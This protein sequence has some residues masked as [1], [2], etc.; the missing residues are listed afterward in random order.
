MSESPSTDLAADIT[1]ELRAEQPADQ[2]G[3]ADSILPP[4]FRHKRS[5]P[6]QSRIEEASVPAGDGAGALAAD[7]SSS[8]A[9][10]ANTLPQPFRGAQKHA[11]DS[12]GTAD[13][14]AT[15]GD[16]PARTSPVL[17]RGPYGGA[18]QGDE[19]GEEDGEEDEDEDGLGVLRRGQ[20]ATRLSTSKIQGRAEPRKPRIGPQYQAVVP[21]WLG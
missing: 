15:S 21:P 18:D 11:R 10:L 3:V 2:L 19:D 13:L 12:P 4:K 5:L 14:G 8:A 9:P 20:K 1:R 16:P 17:A 6:E 7:P